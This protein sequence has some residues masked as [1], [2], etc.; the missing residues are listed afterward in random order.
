MASFTTVAREIREEIYSYL[1]LPRNAYQKKEVGGGATLLLLKI[2]TSLFTLNKQIS[3]EML[4]YFYGQNE[5]V[6]VSTLRQNVQ[7][8][9]RKIALCFSC[10][11]EKQAACRNKVSLMVEFTYRSYSMPEPHT[12]VFDFV[13]TVRDLPDYSLSEIYE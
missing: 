7:F 11:V 9:M 10:D 5:F 4:S 13:C 8:F 3:N 1:L 12:G 2:L 6:A